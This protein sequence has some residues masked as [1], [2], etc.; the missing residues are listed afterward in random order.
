MRFLYH[1]LDTFFTYKTYLNSQIYTFI[2]ILLNHLY[3]ILCIFLYRL[4]QYFENLESVYTVDREKNQNERNDLEVSYKA[5]GEGISIYFEKYSTYYHLRRLAEEL[6][7]SLSVK[8]LTRMV[9]ERCGE[10]IPR[11]DIVLMAL[12]DAQGRHLSVVA[13]KKIGDASEVS[14]KQGDMFDFWVI[15]NRNRFIIS[16]SHQDV[17]FDINQTSRQADLRSLI[18]VPLLYAGRVMGTLRINSSQPDAFTNDDLRLLDAIGTLASSALSNAMLYEKTEELAIR[19][20]LTGLYV[21]RYFFERLKQ[22]HRRF[23]IA[24][25]PLSLLMCGVAC[26]PVSIES[27]SAFSAVLSASVCA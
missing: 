5:K 22:E 7:T 10:F 9:V 16:D 17:R 13:S 25:R 20:S 26:G 3:V 1:Y 2:E 6:V 15:R 8:Q 19:D 14:S 12:A 18:M 11:G 4:D 24:R 21:R 23:L 27:V